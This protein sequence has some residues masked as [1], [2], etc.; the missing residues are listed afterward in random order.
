MDQREEA[1]GSL[2][3][4]ESGVSLSHLIRSMATEGWGGLEWGVGIP[5]TVGGAIVGNAGAYGGSL[6]QVVDKVTVY[7]PGIGPLKLDGGDLQFGYRS[8][9]WKRDRRTL[10]G[11]P[12]EVI[13][14]ADVRVSRTDRDTLQLRMARLVE[15]RKARQPSEP[16]AGSVF[17]NPPHQVAGYLI[18][19]AGLKG[20]RIGDA[21]VSPKHANYV[22]NLGEATSSHIRELVD[23]VQKKVFSQF[24][25]E[26]DLEI[27]LLGEW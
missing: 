11:D 27:E 22:V 26:L 3:R 20:H 12:G 13:L 1:G 9:R 19:K 8:S 5:G 21:Q 23:V 16:S 14:S 24:G 17:K 10:G 4:A 6:S 25:I 7:K 15:E 2:V 18:E